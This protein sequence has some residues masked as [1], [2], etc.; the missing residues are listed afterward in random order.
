[1]SARLNL[2]ILRLILEGNPMST[3]SIT[4]NTIPITILIFALFERVV[5]EKE[6]ADERRDDI[7]DNVGTLQSSLLQEWT[8]T[9]S[10]N[11]DRIQHGSCISL[12]LKLIS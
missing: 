5:R 6:G 11:M 8:R 2:E 4:P 3:A 10:R 7:G 1:M 12:S 9:K